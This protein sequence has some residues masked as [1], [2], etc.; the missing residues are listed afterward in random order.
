M[1]IDLVAK[2][3]EMNVKR[4]EEKLTAQVFGMAATALPAGAV[5]MTANEMNVE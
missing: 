3:R 1:K 5:M 4:K 2:L